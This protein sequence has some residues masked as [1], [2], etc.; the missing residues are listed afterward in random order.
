MPPPIYLH[1][2]DAASLRHRVNALAQDNH[3]RR[4]LAGLRGELE[5]ALVLPAESFPADVVRI[6]SV[7][8]VHDLTDGDTSRYTLCFPEHAE[9]TAGRLSVFAPLGT[10]ILGVSAGHEF[11]WEM[12]G[13]PRR[14]RLLS[15]APPPDFPAAASPAA[16]PALASR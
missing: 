10:A 15:V 7:V 13:G 4:A 12:P 3:S 11:T 8:E 1:D 9:I 5:R 16:R 2:S 14:L 6:G